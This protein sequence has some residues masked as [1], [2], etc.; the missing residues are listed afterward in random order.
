VQ[1][2]YSKLDVHRLRDAVAK[3][4][5]SGLL[6]GMQE[7]SRP[8][9]LRGYRRPQPVQGSARF[10]AS[11]CPDFFGRAVLRS[12]CRA[13]GRGGRI[14][15]LFWGG[16]PSGS[17]KSSVV[18]AGLLPALARGRCL[19][20]KAGLWWICCPVRARWTTGGRPAAGG[21]APL[22]TSLM[23]RFSADAH[24]LAR[25]AQ[26]ILAGRGRAAAGGRPVRGGLHPGRRPWNDR[27]FLDLLYAASPTRAARCARSLPCAPISTTAH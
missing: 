12:N 26:L 20:Q 16:R 6:T 5:R 13:T 17:G 23:S 10:P 1:E 8:P 22:T 15:P 2:I 4:Q 7:Y 14:S 3:A 25:A 21:G 18:R 9:V 24:G 19:D 27:H 11:G